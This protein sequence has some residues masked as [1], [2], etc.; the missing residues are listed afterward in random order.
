MGKYAD[1][2]A[3]YTIQRELQRISMNCKIKLGVQLTRCSRFR[4]FDMIRFSSLIHAKQIDVD[5]HE[6]LFG[7]IFDD[8]HGITQGLREKGFDFLS[9]G[10]GER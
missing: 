3:G 5:P 6:L 7:G 2:L 1:N 10:C 9:I 8:L 4:A